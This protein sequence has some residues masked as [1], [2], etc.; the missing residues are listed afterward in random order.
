MDQIGFG[1]EN[2]DGVGKYRTSEAGKP[3]DA[4]GY[5][6]NLDHLTFDGPEDLAKK[7]A[8]SA[9]VSQ[10]LAA[11]MTSYVLGV[12]VKDGMCIA[13]ASAYAAGATPLSLANV[14]TQVMDP[15]HLQQRVAP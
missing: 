3:I 4:K 8:A 11:Q 7:L 5:V 9:Q 6:E 2:F 10:C 14:L 12:S 1:L 13:P 15:A